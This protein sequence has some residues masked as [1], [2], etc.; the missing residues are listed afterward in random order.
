VTEVRPFEPGHLEGVLRLC[1]AEAWD[2]FLGAPE[3]ALRALQAP[4]VTTVVALEGEEVVGFAEMLSDG[5][6]QAYLA[7]LAVD[8]AHRRKGIGRSLVEAAF[9]AAGGE[10]VDLLSEEDAEGFYRAFRPGSG[11]GF[12]S[13]RR[14][15]RPRRGTPAGNRPPAPP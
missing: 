12:A 2:S 13:T 15:P 5:E 9:A 6:V 3:R 1:A 4:G 10:R 11:G 8:R 14:G 7:L